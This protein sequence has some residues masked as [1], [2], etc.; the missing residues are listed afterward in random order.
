MII[1][2]SRRGIPQKSPLKGLLA[3]A[4]TRG[5]SFEFGWLG[6]I[7]RVAKHAWVERV[8]KEENSA[9]YDITL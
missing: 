4:G 6:F 9:N 2:R 7:Y 8:R 5:Y 1:S 3:K